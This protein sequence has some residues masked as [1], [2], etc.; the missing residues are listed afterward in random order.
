[1]ATAALAFL[2]TACGEAA[3]PAELKFTPEGISSTATVDTPTPLVEPTRLPET[4]PTSNNTINAQPFATHT[5]SPQGE[6]SN[7]EIYLL[8]SR[9][10]CNV[11]CIYDAFFFEPGHSFG[12]DMIS[13]GRFETIE[14]KDS[15]DNLVGYI[16]ALV[17]VT[18]D[19]MANPRVV[20]YA[21]QATTV[22]N[23][24]LNLL[25]AILTQDAVD[26]GL[27]EEFVALEDVI[28]EPQP[29]EFLQSL[30]SRGTISRRIVPTD[31]T[32]EGDSWAFDVLRPVFSN[33]EYADR[34]KEFGES[35]GNVE[36]YDDPILLFPS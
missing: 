10:P 4:T 23:P 33:P 12:I 21:V 16:D 30:Y 20:Y 32:F 15:N 18:K 2:A 7:Q 3:Q 26:A 19:S 8:A 13:T 36:N 25:R 22:D 1:M 34:I 9:L 17:A 6:L 27:H 35:R 5:R 24:S 29:L 31:L 14:V 11:S 28:L